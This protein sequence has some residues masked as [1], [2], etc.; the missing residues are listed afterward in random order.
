MIFW[1]IFSFFFAYIFPIFFSYMGEWKST[2]ELATISLGIGILLW[3]ISS[4]R[5]LRKYILGPIKKKRVMDRLQDYGKRTTAIIVDKIEN[6]KV[7][8]RYDNLD[9]VLGFDNLVGEYTE[10]SI[11]VVDSKPGLNRYEIGNEI[12][13]VLNDEGGTPAFN[14]EGASVSVRN[15]WAFIWFIF[16]IVYAIGT[17]YL[18]YEKYSDGMGWRFL[19]PGYPWV[20]APIIGMFSF[21]VTMSTNIYGQSPMMKRLIGGLS[22]NEYS[23]L[24]LYGRNVVGEIVSYKQTG[25]Y[26]NEQPQVEI[27]VRYKD[28]R[29]VLIDA[30][31]KLVISLLDVGKLD[32]GPVDIRY[33]PGNRELFKIVKKSN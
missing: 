25:T 7:L 29:G 21:S 13:V 19:S 1:I 3:F 18:S 8:G 6:G 16:N 4:L 17:F 14:L 15:H 28:D 22:E 32:T 20:W 31:K 33:L 23:Q 9:L 30:K 2:P 24:I 5:I 27:R 12:T 11:D 10:V 26:I